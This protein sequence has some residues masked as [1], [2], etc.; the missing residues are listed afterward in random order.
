MEH[1]FDIDCAIKY[2]IEKAVLLKNISFWLLKNK[3]N[4]A[5][6]HDGYVWTYNSSKA[7]ADL[8]PYMSPQKISRQLREMEEDGLIISGNYNN[9]AYD[10]TKWYTLPEFAI[11]ENET[12]H[13]SKMKNGFSKN[14]QPI[15]DINTDI[16]TD[17][18]TSD[19]IESDSHLD[20]EKLRQ[21]WNDVMTNS[22]KLIK[23][24]PTRQRKLKKFLKDFNLDEVKFRNYLEY[25]NND[26]SCRW[27]FE[28]RPRS[29]G[30][31]WQPKGFDYIVSEKCY[32][33]IKE[34]Y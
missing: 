5:H 12:F 2:G 21:V 14:E 17:T 22:H 7:F 15:P 28:T 34:E 6:I 3:A 20:Y 16:N 11:V 23:V 32:L 30:Q 8:F 27:M 29:D 31:T 1:S 26:D 13:C 4:G 10:R 24:T 9:S 19:S 18:N 25:V 33:K